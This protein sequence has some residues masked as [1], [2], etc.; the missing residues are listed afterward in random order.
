MPYSPEFQCGCYFEAN[1]PTGAPSPGCVAC[2]GP[3]DCPAAA[4]ACNAGF[5]EAK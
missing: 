2:N 1:V 5:C 4:P 3:A